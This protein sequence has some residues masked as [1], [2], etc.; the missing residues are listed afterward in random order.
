[1]TLG[2]ALLGE[3]AIIKSASHAQAMT[4]FVESEQRCDNKIEPLWLTYSIMREYRLRYAKAVELHG[5]VWRPWNEPQA[6]LE[7]GMQY[8]QITVFTHAVS[9]MQQWHGIDLPLA[10][11]VSGYAS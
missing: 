10:A 2:D 6:S 7:E 9:E 3:G 5:G 4:M 11:D 1:M 8:G